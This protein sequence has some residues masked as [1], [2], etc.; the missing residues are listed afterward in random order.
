VAGR[1]RHDSAA[2]GDTLHAVAAVL[3]GRPD[4]AAGLFALALTRAGERLGWP[5]PWR[6]LLRE[7]RRHPNEEVRA[8]ALE[9]SMQAS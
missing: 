1:V 7:L 5:A 8:L 3:A 2:G 4:P 9:V 6:D